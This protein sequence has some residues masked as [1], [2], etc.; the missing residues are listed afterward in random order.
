MRFDYRS[1][2]RITLRISQ[3]ANR[4][5]SVTILTIVIVYIAQLAYTGRLGLY[6]HPRYFA[7]TIAMTAVAGIMVGLSL[8]TNH[9]HHAHGAKDRRYT[10]L[11][12][13]VVITI[14]LV[15]PARSLTS[16][17]ISQRSIDS[18][19]TTTNRNMST[20]FAGSSK[21][22]KLA[23]WV[24][25]LNIHEDENYYANKPAK[26]SGF[27][28]D[29]DLGGDVV[30]VARFA[31]SCCAVDAQPMGVP[32]LIENWRTLH[33]QDTWV[34][35]EGVFKETQTASGAQLALHPNSVNEINEP[36]NPYAN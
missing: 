18:V 26:I 34:E 24:Q 33:Q 16:A 15:L 19:S 22:L 25:L 31:V 6:I 3:R 7:F 11:P 17:T 13:C 29:A 4:H 14:I 10:Y 8:L 5:G 12:L 28:Y 35:V 21:S 36:A 23:D 9:H 27:V 20:L 30:W 32:V 2:K 1:V